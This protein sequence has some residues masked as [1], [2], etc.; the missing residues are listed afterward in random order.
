MLNI[1]SRFTQRAE[2]AVAAPVAAHELRVGDGTDRWTIVERNNTKLNHQRYV[3]LRLEYPGEFSYGIRY[4]RPDELV[5]L[6][7]RN[8]RPTN[9]APWP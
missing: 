4:Y 7:V 1:I 6:T 9:T 2:Q 5:P 3:R 8:R